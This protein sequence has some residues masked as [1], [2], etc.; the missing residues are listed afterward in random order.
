MR[1]TPRST[2]HPAKKNSRKPI[3][4][5]VNTAIETASTKK[6]NTSG[7]PKLRGNNITK[8]TVL[9]NEE[10]SNRFEGAFIKERSQFRRKGKKLDRS[11]LY[12]IILNEWLQEKGY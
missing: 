9:L 11:L 4:E 3:E 2:H 5:R 8:H 12:E 6:T 7:R 10:T 1:N